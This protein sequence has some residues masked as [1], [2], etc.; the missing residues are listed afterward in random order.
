MTHEDP[1]QNGVSE[2][3]AATLADALALATARGAFNPTRLRDVRSAVDRTARMIGRPATELPAS[4]KA[5]RPL[6]LTILPARHGIT[7]KSLAN[8]RADLGALLAAVGLADRLGRSGVQLSSSWAGLIEAVPL[9]PQK[10]SIRAFARWAQEADYAPDAI[11]EA[12]IEMFRAWRTTRTLDLNVAITVNAIRRIWNNAVRT[13]PGWPQ[14]RL[15]AP[16]DP[17]AVALPRSDFSAAFL[18]DLEGYL[19]ALSN[20][21]PLRPGFGRQLSPLTIRDRG[22]ALLRMASI[23]VAQG[24]EPATIRSLAD[25]VTEASMRAALL[26]LYERNGGRERGWPAGAV[27]FACTVVHVA[28]AWCGVTGDDL[29]KLRALRKLVTPKRQGLSRRNL[30]RLE[31]FDEPALLARF[32]ALPDELMRAA[33]ALVDEGCHVRAAETHETGIALALL[34]LNPMRRQNLVDLDLQAHFRRDHR[35]NLLGLAIPGTAVKNGV[36]IEAE[37]PRALARRIA[38]HLQVHHKLRCSVATTKLF[39]SRAGGARAPEVLARAIKRAVG[40]YVGAEFNV[41]AQRHLAVKLLLDDNTDNVAVAQ[42]LLGHRDARTTVSMY[43]TIT[44]RAAQ[45]SWQA[46]IQR[47]LR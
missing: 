46:S 26:A 6:L 42:R 2:T 9:S 11:D 32:L 14:R 41:H 19:A 4:P 22:R 23:L 29:T 21:D 40:R 44:T 15:V 38:L 3:A 36:G 47:R 12:V 43:G 13:V 33:D 10:A 1:A 35:G 27:T 45:K 28:E 31:Q 25:L 39:P 18:A 34:L 5:L 7:R 24:R 30:D 16:K 8:V 17:R 20:P 37:L